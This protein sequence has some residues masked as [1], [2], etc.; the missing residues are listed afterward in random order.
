V[1]TV[2]VPLDDVADTVL[3]DELFAAD[4]DG[5]PLYYRPFLERKPRQCAAAVAAVARAAPGGVAVHC[6]IGRD[7]TGLV[8]MLVLALAGVEPE[9]IA[10]DYAASASRLEPLLA[11]MGEPEA[12]RLAEE[13]CAREGTT[14]RGAILETLTAF[15]LEAHLRAGGLR[16]A[17][18]GALR[19]R[20]LEPR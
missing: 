18:V 14:V 4:L 13:R 6:V 16:A 2:H 11:A 20:V 5:S 9:A 8:A 19:E 10:E 12:E 3:W 15:D 17:D 1:S 7:R